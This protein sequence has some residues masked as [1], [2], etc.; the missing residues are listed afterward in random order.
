MVSKHA[1]T[2]SQLSPPPTGHGEDLAYLWWLKRNKINHPVASHQKKLPTAYLKDLRIHRLSV[3]YRGAMLNIHRYRLRASSC[4][5]I[6]RNSMTTIA[7]EKVQWYAGLWDFWDLLVDMFDFSHFADPKYLVF[8]ISNFLLY[9]WYDVPYVYLTDYAITNGV[10]EKDASILISIIGIVNMVGEVIL[11]WLGDRQ[12][13]NASLTYAVCMALCGGV[14]AFIPLITDYWSLL[15]VSGAFGF[16]IAAN[17]SLT[18]IILVELI[19]LDRFTNAYGL[20]LLVQGVANLVGPPL[21]GWLCDITGSF[22]LSF[23]LAGLIIALSGLMLVILPITRRCKKFKRQ[24][25]TEA[26]IRN[27]PVKGRSK[28]DSYFDY[29]TGR[30]VDD[31]SKV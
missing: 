21:A 20:L 4:P 9:T 30:G 17:Y 23:Y 1:A 8:A 24:S 7:K 31:N 11:G 27:E 3:T 16:F 15:F 19:T 10:S 28:D 22:D 12:W 6:Y 14:I 25:S 5:D 2:Q 26:S 29:S 13:A 18:C